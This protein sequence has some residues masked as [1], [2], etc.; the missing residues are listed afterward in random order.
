M[1]KYE[2]T[3]ATKSLKR[4]GRPRSTTREED[5][6]IVQRH[7]DNPFQ[8]ASSTSQQVHVSRQTVSRRLKE[9]GLRARRPAFKPKLSAE[10]RERRNEWARA[11]LRWNLA[12]WGEVLFTD[13]ASFELDSKDRRMVCYRRTQQRYNQEMIVE[14]MNRGYGSIMVWGGIVGGLKTPLIRLEGRINSQRYI[15]EVL[16]PHAVPFIRQNHVRHFMHDNA[17]AHRAALTQDFLRDAGIDVLDWPPVSPDLNPLENLWS[18]IKQQLKQQPP[19]H[20]ADELFENLRLLWDRIPAEVVEPLTSSMWRR[21]Q[22]VH[23]V[24]GG[25]TKY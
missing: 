1:R 25:H 12:A 15:D 3:G 22:S 17:P 20:N 2:V 24:D 11:H 13:E 5:R 19:A 10:N 14:K 23:A 7:E 18:W 8:T 6:D 16:A 9:V 21:V 4:S